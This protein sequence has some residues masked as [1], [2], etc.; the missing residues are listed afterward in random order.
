MSKIWWLA[1]QVPVS[2]FRLRSWVGGE[3]MDWDVAPEM[4]PNLL[5]IVPR[6]SGLHATQLRGSCLRHF[7]C[8][9]PYV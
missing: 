2:R 8:R 4:E 9:K 5:S 3:G 1:G 6:Q 7:C